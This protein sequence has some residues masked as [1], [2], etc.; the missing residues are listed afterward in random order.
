MMEESSVRTNHLAVLSLVVSA[1]ALLSPPLISGLVL[2]PLAI[3]DG[4]F[5]WLPPA[6]RA[7]WLF[8]PAVAIAGIA[9]GHVARH[10][11]RNG[12]AVR[13]N[14]IALAGL[15]IGYAALVHSLSAVIVAVLGS[16]VLKGTD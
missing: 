7:L 15:I 4:H 16:H 14:G 5:S 3:S 1:T 11:I 2:M 10:K 6:M 8:Q 12:P 13:G 9:L